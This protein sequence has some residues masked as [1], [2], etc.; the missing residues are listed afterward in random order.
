MVSFN[1]AAPSCTMTAGGTEHPDMPLKAHLDFLFYE[2]FDG[3]PE[4]HVIEVKS[5]SGI[6]DER[7]PNGK[8]SSTTN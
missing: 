2:D 7:I 4:L 3:N 8:T 5:V 6:P 1:P